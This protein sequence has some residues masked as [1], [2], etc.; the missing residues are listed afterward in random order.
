M[1]RVLKGVV[2]QEDPRIVDTPKFEK[3]EVEVVE[4]DDETRDNIMRNIRKK[5][6]QAAQQLKDAQ[7]ASEIIKQEAKAEAEKILEE[8]K[9]EADKIKEEAREAGHQEGFEAGKAEGFEKIQQ[10]QHQIILD[11]NDKAERTIKAAQEEALEYVTKAEN[12]I[13]EMVMSIA[14]KVI[15][16]HFIDMPQMVLPL[17]QNAIQKVKDQPQVEIRVAPDVYELVIMARSEYLASMEGKAELSIVSDETL[18]VG[19]CVIESPNGTVD[20][21]LST[22]LELI[23]QSIRDVMK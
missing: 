22:Q 7:I 6:E 5:E 16:Q 19:D 15:P 17:V 9:Q 10:E 20:A 12:T 3:P 8:A 14:D 13:A 2:W 23:K 18:K 21:K 1:S 4:M 11:A